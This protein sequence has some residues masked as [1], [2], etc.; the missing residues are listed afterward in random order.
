[1]DTI[2]NPSP[3]SSPKETDYGITGLCLV[4]EDLFV[5]GTF[6]AIGGQSRSRLAKISTSGSGEAD[7]LWN[8]NPDG[9]PFGTVWDGTSLYA[10]GQWVNIGGVFRP[11]L[12]KLSAVGTGAI[13]TSWAP[14]A[15]FNRTG[16]TALA[17]DG[18]QLYVGTRNFASGKTPRVG[19]VFRVST[20][21][22]GQVD[23]TWRP[24]PGPTDYYVDAIAVT[25]S[26]VFMG[27]ESTTAA[28]IR[29]LLVKLSSAGAGAID[30][31]WNPA[32]TG[33]NDADPTTVTTVRSL[34]LSGTSLYVGGRFTTIGGQ[35]R[36]HF[37]KLP[38]NGPAL[39]D[40]RFRADEIGRAS[41]RERVL[42]VV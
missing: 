37:A 4:G 9:L 24:A 36:A 12:A 25:A 42:Q 32:V 22:N 26:H 38:V 13:E 21:G 2:W 7:P 33:L 20:T 34:L 17:L 8:P 16:V 39:V 10:G 27:G 11:R 14:A 41:C 35:A 6:R 29:A 1:M 23:T 30:E 15:D 18:Q 40:A 19:G 3:I 31:S 28:G 5:G